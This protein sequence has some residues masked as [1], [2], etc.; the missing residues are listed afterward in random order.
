[1]AVAAH[2]ELQITLRHLKVSGH[3]PAFGFEP[4]EDPGCGVGSGAVASSCGRLACPECGCGGTNLS[5]I[6]LS[7][8][9]AGERIDCDFCGH[10]WIHGRS[11][12]YVLSRAE[13][14]ECTCPDPCERD[15]ANE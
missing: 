7:H 5:T 8:L 12:F 11:P 9:H 13:T 3:S 6:Q 14:V 4:C 2:P 1:M 15:H 10:T